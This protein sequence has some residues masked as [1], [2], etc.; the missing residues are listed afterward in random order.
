MN[1]GKLDLVAQKELTTLIRLY[2]KPANRQLIQITC[3]KR[4]IDGANFIIKLT[5]NK[6]MEKYFLDAFLVQF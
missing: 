1:P 5:D 4:L 2:V 3:F 6:V